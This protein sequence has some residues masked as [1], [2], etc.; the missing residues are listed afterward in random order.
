MAAACS[1]ASSQMAEAHPGWDTDP[2]RGTV[3]PGGG[4]RLLLPLTRESFCN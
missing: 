2:F 4:N 1:R 3:S